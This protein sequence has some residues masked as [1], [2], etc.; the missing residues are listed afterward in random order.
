[1]DVVLSTRFVP[2]EE[3]F[4]YWGDVVVH[5]FRPLRVSGLDSAP[6]RGRI[7][8]R[9]M[10]SL[11]VS[12]VGASASRIVRRPQLIAQEI[13]EHVIVGL[14]SRNTATV[15]QDGR[16]ATLRPGDLAF[17]DSTR[18]YALG[19][20]D[21]FEIL[22]FRVP[23]RALA[24]REDELRRITALAIPGD[25]GLGRLVS[26]FLSTLAQPWQAACS[27]EARQ[28]VAG[29]VLDLLATLA[30]ESLGAEGGRDVAPPTLALRIRRFIDEH[31]AEPDLSPE[32]IAAAHHISVRYL[33]RLFQ[34]EG[35]TVSRHIRQ[36]R[37]QECRRELE[38]GA[39]TRPTVAAVAHRW[40]FAT[41][42][43]FSR[44][45]RATYGIS[46][47]QCRRPPGSSE[48]AG[49]CGEV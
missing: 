12:T 31:L 9:R 24:L 15:V 28:K 42:A 20:P 7:S 34:V 6:S 14:Q 44:V 45:F 30:R 18:P 26:S 39:R 23:R 48:A 33:H 17:Y 46:P 3:R 25:E 38:V 2:A 29:T 10:S 32:V 41:P 21:A 8:A 1:V 35:T 49:R 43:H 19:S 13:G 40:G 5:T 47:S 36:L 22:S 27:V 37:L 4:A 16:E 11:Q